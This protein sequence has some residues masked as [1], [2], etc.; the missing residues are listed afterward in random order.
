MLNPKVYLVVAFCALVAVAAGDSFNDAVAASGHDHDVADGQPD[1]SQPLRARDDA[2]PP[3]D[4][5]RTMVLGIGNNGQSVGKKDI[6]KGS[7]YEDIKKAVGELCPLSQAGPGTMGY[8]H[9]EKGVTINSIPVKNKDGVLSYEGSFT[10]KVGSSHV[11]F[12]GVKE[13]L[14]DAVAWTIVTVMN[15]NCW[16]PNFLGDEH[17]LELCK[18]PDITMVRIDYVGWLVVFITADT[19]G[20]AYPRDMRACAQ[21]GWAAGEVKEKTEKKIREQI[22]AN[23]WHEPLKLKGPGYLSV[24]TS[25]Y[26]NSTATGQGDGWCR[27]DAFEYMPG[28][29]CPPTRL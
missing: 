28:T 23:K 27:K 21:E 10:V 12:P 11:G 9:T 2:P 7:V 17:D 25:C 29:K 20:M 3:W 8:C 19:K 24:E 13:I 18:A 16:K 26:T 22:K 5:R 1:S 6:D 14:I 4:S 15:E